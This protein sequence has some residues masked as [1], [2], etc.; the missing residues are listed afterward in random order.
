MVA[1]MR[2][3]V[4]HGVTGGGGGCW[5]RVESDAQRVAVRR[6]GLPRGVGVR[7]AGLTLLLAG[8]V[9]VAGGS[10]AS[11][12]DHSGVW[13]ETAGPGSSHQQHTA[14]RLDDGRVLV[15][16]DN[17]DERGRAQ[18]ELYDPDSDT[19]AATD[20]MN[21]GRYNHK[22]VK[23]A[24][25]RVLAV[26]T[27]GP[28]ESIPEI[29]D[30]SAAEGERWTEVADKP[31]ERV[32]TATLLTG[33]ECATE[34]PAWCATVLVTGWDANSD[35]AAA[36]F[37]PEGGSAGEGSWT[38]ADPPG[39][40]FYAPA[41]RL[42]GA[43]CEAEGSP[44]A[45]CG[46]VL[47]ARGDTA[48]VFDPTPVDPD[49]GRVGQWEATGGFQQ[50]RRA[51]SLTLLDDGRVLAAGGVDSAGQS[52]ASAELYEPGAGAWA[53]TADMAEKRVRHSATLLE[54]GSVLVSGG[55]DCLASAEVFD[56]A[57]D[58]G[59]AANAPGAFASAGLMGDG[60]HDHTTTV[61]G[62]GRVLAVGGWCAPNS[63][64]VYLPEHLD[65][66]TPTPEVDA[67]DPATGLEQ[68]GVEVTISGS[69]FT[70]ASE[71]VFGDQPAGEFQVD[72]H[73]QITAVAPTGQA[74]DAMVRVTTPE[75]G[76]SPADDADAVFTYVEPAGLWT[77]V[78]Q[79]PEPAANLE[80]VALGSGEVLAI[81][82][83]SEEAVR[84]DP[85]SGS[86]VGTVDPPVDPVVVVT[87]ADGRALVV[88][89]DDTGEGE[90]FSAAVYDP[91]SDAWALTSAP[92]ADPAKATAALLDDG[93]V[94]VVSDPRDLD[95]P[96]TSQVYDPASDEWRLTEGQPEPHPQ[97]GATATRLADGRVVLAGGGASIFARTEQAQVFDPDSE[98]WT[99]IGMAEPRAYHDA[100]LLDDGRALVAGG[101]GLYQYAGVEAFDPAGGDGGG[102]QP[103]PS[104][105]H[106]RAGHTLTR[107]GDGSALAAGGVGSGG[108]QAHSEVF[109]P[110]TGDW[111]PTGRLNQAR[112]WHA[113]IRLETGCGT[114][115]GGVV[116]VGGQTASGRGNE[117][118]SV[119]LYTPR[120]QVT[121]VAPASAPAGSEVT[122]SGFGLAGVDAVSF[123]DTAVEFT[124]ESPTQLTATAP[125]GTDAGESVHVTVRNDVEDSGQSL[126][127][128]ASDADVFTFEDAPDGGGAADDAVGAAAIGEIS[129]LAATATSASE[130]ELSWSAVGDATGSSVPGYVVK[131]SREPIT[132]A[133]DFDEAFALCGGVCEPD[134][135]P[136]VGGELTLTVLDLEADTTYHYAVRPRTADGELGPMSNVAS[137]TTEADA[138]G[139]DTAPEQ[140]DAP[141]PACGDDL[142]AASFTDRDA[143]PQV[144]LPGVDCAAA[145]GIVQG[146][147]D[148]SFGP[149][150]GLRRDQMAAFIARTLE[151]ADVA[152][153][154]PGEQ[155]FADVA[156]GSTHDEAIHRLAAAGIVA[157]GPGELSGDR[158]GP[159]RV[160][161][162]DQMASFLVRAGEYATDQQLTAGDANRFTD[163]PD[164]N[165]H[166]DR[167]ATA[168]ALELAAGYPDGT[169]RPANQ[170]RRDQM[171][172]FTAR[173]LESLTTG[174]LATTNK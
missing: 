99:S 160:I 110:G 14:V 130:I 128:Q 35:P 109:R 142:P 47:A 87:L 30:P 31:L 133:G 86:I 145:H 71:V 118:A 75:G 23:L 134:P 60:R 81:N 66:A 51:H 144:H 18:A 55:V 126:T 41:V 40:R 173:F 104:L 165:V 131:Q 112:R 115:C 26:G 141:D 98:T 152:L 102:W 82:T 107:L 7:L 88:S 168:A 63:A 92:A 78:A 127:S 161:R 48:E 72:T 24:D 33:P 148:G 64:D 11:A 45:W 37:D 147:A 2:H 5:R 95:V 146:F 42:D 91:G 89:R 156:A 85:D 6:V 73:D 157:G 15:T 32:Q 19:W 171:A 105:V 29:Y 172:T 121:G 93:R 58:D 143:I 46:K 119:E 84:Y 138:A 79:L 153:P 94:L 159:G 151:A 162:R 44:P 1:Q 166:S 68:G 96:T 70:G 61:L 27:F 106:E 108:V 43:P 77:T 113:A 57:G 34:P 12:Q 169:Y 16:G 117:T 36:V 56:P 53:E 167:V 21:H 67:L 83:T 69:G 139:G 39:D 52:V 9:V 129:D 149:A 97:R 136:Q 135:V 155:R 65:P 163:V 137:A 76:T 17:P 123:G 154:E 10:A 20:S 158:Y 164:G 59:N 3:E 116:A 111:R 8:V 170:V 174:T 125:E 25:G 90:P 100:V 62:D 38:P 13:R 74:G 140:T 101:L 80:A 120:P 50:P 54:D 124:V 49:T 114:R 4:K 22:L 150:L 28:T 122:I 103:V 132:D